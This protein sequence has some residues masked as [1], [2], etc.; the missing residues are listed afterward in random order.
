MV[1]PVRTREEF[2]ALSQSRARGRSGPIRITRAPLP[3]RTDAPGPAAEARV[4]YA[5][6]TRVGTAVVRNRVRRRLRAVMAT[7][8]PADG[9][10]PDLYL[11]ATRP[12]VVA[13]SAAE[14]RRHVTTA[15]RATASIRTGT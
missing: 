5:V 3:R 7:L 15:L 12:E 9:L 10:T 4:A 2:A 11:V 14:L 13:L 1:A 8:G 6:S